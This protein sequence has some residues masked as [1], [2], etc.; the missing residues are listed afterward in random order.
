M[1]GLKI[2][3]VECHRVAIP[4]ASPRFAWRRGLNGGP[5]DGEG[6]VPRI[7][8]DDGFDSGRVESARQSYVEV[9]VFDRSRRTAAVRVKVWTDAGAS[10]WSDPISVDS[11]LLH[12]DQWV[13]RWIGVPEPSPMPKVTSATLA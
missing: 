11:G 3:H 1:V 12:Q 5:P 9:P 6:G 4:G 8:T 7:T 13:A 10:R 2:T